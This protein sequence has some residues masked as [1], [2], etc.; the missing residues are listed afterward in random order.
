MP[1]LFRLEHVFVRSGRELVVAGQ[2]AD[3]DADAGD[4]PSTVLPVR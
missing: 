2:F 3:K 1:A 4:A